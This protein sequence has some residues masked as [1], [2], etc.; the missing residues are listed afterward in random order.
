MAYFSNFAP[1]EN[2]EINRILNSN[3][4]L[5]QQINRNLERIESIED[6]TIAKIVYPK[7]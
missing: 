6:Q 4:E 5:N 1:N 2:P 7:V 3:A